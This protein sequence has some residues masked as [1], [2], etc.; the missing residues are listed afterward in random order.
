MMG[1]TFKL[2]AYEN[3]EE[4]LLI[5]ITLLLKTFVFGKFLLVVLRQLLMPGQSKSIFFEANAA[6]L[7][8]YWALYSNVEVFKV[9]LISSQKKPVIPTRFLNCYHAQTLH[10]PVHHTQKAVLQNLTDDCS[11]Y[12][13]V[14]VNE[15]ITEE[16]FKIDEPSRLMSLKFLLIRDA[17]K[18]LGNLEKNY[19]RD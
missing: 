4:E 13:N 16:I 5:K 19:G 3:I 7:L 9:L 17:W 6:W 15:R 11:V 18:S 10:K 12:R 14:A 1:W 8:L 2:S